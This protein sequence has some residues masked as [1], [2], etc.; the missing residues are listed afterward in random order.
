MKY[1]RFILSSIIL[2]LTLLQVHAQTW[3][4]YPLQKQITHT[5]PF[6]GIVF[7][8]D[9]DVALK[10]LGNH[11]QLEFAYML[12]SEVVSDSGKYD[13]KAVE[14]VLNQAKNRGHQ[15]ILRFRDT[16]PGITKASVPSYILARKDYTSQLLKV[17][18]A[19][20]FIPDWSNAEWKRFALEFFS[21]FAAK[22]DADPRL[23][24]LQV[25]FGS[26]AEYHLY[27]GPFALGK[28]FPDK[29]YQELFL[30]HVNSLMTTTPWSISIDAA[31]GG[32]SPLVAKPSLKNLNFGLFDDS[33]MH[34]THSKTDAEY[35][36]ASWLF[37][38]ADR[39]KTKVAG[40]EFSYYTDF[41]Q[42][43][44][45]DLP[46]GPHG[47]SFESFATQYHLSYIIGN[48]QYD[49]QKPA[50]I[51]QAAL[52]TGYHFVVKSY[53]SNGSTTEVEI[54]NTGIA[55]CY[56]DVY[57]SL[58]TTK[59]NTSLKGL[60]GTEIR[61][62]TINAPI[63]STTPLTLTSP[64]LLSTQEI[65]YEAALSGTVT[66]VDAEMA[67]NTSLQ[68]YP[69]PVKDILYLSNTAPWAL[70]DLQ[71]HKLKEGNSSTV[72][73]SELQSGTYLLQIANT[74]RKIIIE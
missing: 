29:A 65:Q 20:T 66:H 55:P 17:E 12:P 70:F 5:Q 35:N 13:W 30:T 46:N 48:D 19:N 10:A 31:D 69:N 33:F 38:G 15:C 49:H 51:G 56:F 74:W 16:Y 1:H 54:Q 40:G 14:A 43:H 59:A 71:G 60:V 52:A 25:G 24:Y 50:R 36:R 8:T 2:S 28:T 3:I 63:S 72:P 37:M 41:D 39:W 7:W 58:G 53:K 64:K 6:T 62:F 18:G 32:T 45:L 21:M 61:K 67:P 27:D 22:Y 44:V 42:Q 23:A 47:R 34:E 4:D 26:Y 68:I 57:P 73:V 9:N 11:V